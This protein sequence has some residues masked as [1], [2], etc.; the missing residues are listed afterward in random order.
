MVAQDAQN[1]AFVQFS[2]RWVSQYEAPY[3]MELLFKVEK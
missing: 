3:A 2:A 1:L